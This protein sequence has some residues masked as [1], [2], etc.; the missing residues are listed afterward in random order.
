MYIYQGFW[1]D[2]VNLPSHNMTDTCLHPYGLKTIQ[3]PS[4]STPSY[5]NKPVIH[6]VTFNNYPTFILSETHVA[7]LCIITHQSHFNP[8]MD[9]LL[10]NCF[11]LSSSKGARPMR[12]IINM[13]SAN[14]QQLRL[15]V[16]AGSSLYHTI[17]P[18]TRSNVSSHRAARE[19]FNVMTIERAQRF[20]WDLKHTHKQH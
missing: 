2:K 16:R 10:I 13:D 12:A 6:P 5:N 11:S 19:K 1:K 9:T 4:E 20:C 8:E 17:T 18:H 15:P 7:L 3:W 14:H